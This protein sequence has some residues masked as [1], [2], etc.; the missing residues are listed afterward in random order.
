V[1]KPPSYRSTRG[2]T[3]QRSTQLIQSDF[4][5]GLNYVASATQLHPNET[6]DCLNVD[7]PPQG[8]F[9]RRKAIVEANPACPTGDF[10]G[11]LKYDKVNGSNQVLVGLTNGATASMRDLTAPTTPIHTFI[12]S[13]L[14]GVVMNDLL[15]LALGHSNDAVRYD[16]TNVAALGGGF[17]DNPDS[18]PHGNMPRAKCIAVWQGSVWVANLLGNPNEVRWSWPNEPEDFPSWAVETIDDGHESDEIVALVPHHERLLVF[19][20]NSVHAITGRGPKDYRIVPLTSTTGTISQESV[21]RTDTDVFFFDWPLGV[22]R[23]GISGGPGPAFGKLLPI[24]EDGRVPPEAKAGITVSWVGSRVWVSVPWRDSPHGSSRNGR[25]FILD[26]R[27]GG[28]TASDVGISQAVTITPSSEAFYAIAATTHPTQV[29]YSRVAKLEQA[30][31]LDHGSLPI[32]GRYRTSWLD[33]NDPQVGKRWRRVGMVH[34]GNAA[35]TTRT[36]FDYST[37]TSRTAQVPGLVGSAGSTWGTAVWGAG[38]WTE[39][40]AE[41]DTSR[42]ERGSVELSNSTPG[43]FEVAQITSSFIPKRRR[44]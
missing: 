4:T 10:T 28:W 31:S 35:V 11:V 16:G 42:V 6:P 17:A 32:Y 18:L 38:L 8:G 33:A 14:R 37:A 22:Q 5:A 34:S 19:K 9:R 36:Y 40:S 24:L 44:D 7:L 13:P 41:S 21:V 27:T 25:T 12:S 39:T 1:L 2:Q 29:G 3:G 23:L 26:S 20:R 15:Y 30:G 43:D